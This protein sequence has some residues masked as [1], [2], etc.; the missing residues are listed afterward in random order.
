MKKIKKIAQ[1]SNDCVACGCCIK[2]CMFNAITVPK[3]ITAVV[4]ADNCVACG[5][6]KMVCPASVIKMIEREAKSE[7]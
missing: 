5:K 7:N 6:C 1:V 4:N 3:G 2:A